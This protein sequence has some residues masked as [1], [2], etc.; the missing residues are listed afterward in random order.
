MSLK[1]QSYVVKWKYDKKMETTSSCGSN[2]P[3][4]SPSKLHLCCVG[5]IVAC[6]AH[7][8]LDDKTSACPLTL[9]D[10][11]V[12]GLEAAAEV[13][14]VDA[15]TN[16]AVMLSTAMV[17]VEARVIARERSSTSGLDSLLSD[18]DGAVAADVAIL[19]TL[20]APERARG[21]DLVAQAG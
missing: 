11:P 8:C 21:I 1:C 14:G 3:L 16:V 9:L 17:L 19:A 4:T 2:C 12:A 6:M 7:W 18:L 10:L 15:D 20:V 13:E 5:D